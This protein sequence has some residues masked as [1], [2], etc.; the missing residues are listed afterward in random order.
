MIAALRLVL[1]GDAYLPSHALQ[2]VQKQETHEK[3]VPEFTARIHT[4]TD[5]QR[6]VLDLAMQG[7]VNKIIAREMGITE[8]TVKAHLSACFRVLGVKNR[9]EAVFAA[10]NSGMHGKRLQ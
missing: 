7:K 5:R 1:A 6:E 9:T 8:A 3:A 2:H 4:L 10:A